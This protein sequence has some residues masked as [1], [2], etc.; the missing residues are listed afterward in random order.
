MK[1]SATPGWRVKLLQQNVEGAV[2]VKAVVLVVILVAAGPSPGS[3]LAAP[4]AATANRCI[5]Y[6]YLAYPYKRPGAVRMSSDRQNYFRDCIAKD[7]NV[8]E[9][10]SAKP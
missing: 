7:G 6:S 5:R 9:P 4:S 10:A 1:L 8:P 3:A 2:K